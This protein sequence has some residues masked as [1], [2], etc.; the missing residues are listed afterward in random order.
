MS[1]AHKIIKNFT[2]D[3]FSP[4]LKE[5][6][7]K[8]LVDSSEQAE[9]EEALM[10]LWEDQN[11]KADAGTERSYQNFRR[12]IA[13][14]QRKATARYTLRRWAQVAAVLLI[15]LLSIVASYLYI[16][17]NEEHTELVEYYVPRGEQKQITLPD[18]TTAYL[19]SGT[20]LVYP[21][22]FTGDIR[23]VYLIGEAN[24]D[25]KKDKQHPFIVKTNHL[26]VKVLGTKFNV[27]SHES[28]SEFEVMLYEGCVDVESEFNNKQV[29]VLMAPGDIVKIDKTT[30]NM[31]QMNISTIANQGQSRKFYF[32]DKKLEDITNQLERHFQKK[33]V[34]TNPQLK[35]IKYD[36]IFANDETIEQILN[37]LNASQQMSIIYHDNTT[38]EIR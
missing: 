7:W 2:S 13:P 30:G 36:A 15:P 35:S 21:Q 18:G 24:F 22:K 9:K 29:E 33:I 32:I 28:D 11:F 10:E 5:K 14:R 25:V 8:W 26:K 12:K 4:E 6:L 38:I 19:N 27:Q 23:S 31:S 17:S 37:Y 16:Q 3:K 1:N 34:I 20:L